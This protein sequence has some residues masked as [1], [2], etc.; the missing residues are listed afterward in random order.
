VVQ[1]EAPTLVAIK[2]EVPIITAENPT[3]FTCVLH[4]MRESIDTL[5]VHTLLRK[6][7]KKKPRYQQKRSSCRRD[8]RRW[9][10]TRK[11]QTSIR[12]DQRKGNPDTELNQGYQG[13]EERLLAAR[14]WMH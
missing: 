9:E 12:G 2:E 13:E 5:N 3:N 11:F 8:T 6:E 1:E 10:K 4:A 14:L 7:V